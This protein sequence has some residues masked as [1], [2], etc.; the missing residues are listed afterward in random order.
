MLAFALF[1]HLKEIL[2]PLPAK[3]KRTGHLAKGGEMQK[4]WIHISSSRSQL[5]RTVDS[6]VLPPSTVYLKYNFIVIVMLRNFAFV[7]FLLQ[8]IFLNFFGPN[9]IGLLHC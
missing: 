4:E 9:P 2:H 3:D 6:V 7:R 1:G 8:K 5:S